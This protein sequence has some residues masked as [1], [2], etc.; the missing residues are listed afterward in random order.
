MI[1]VCLVPMYINISSTLICYLS[2]FI[3]TLNS[4]QNVE[5]LM[6]R[7]EYFTTPP[8]IAVRSENKRHFSEVLRS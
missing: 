8:V 4:H 3:N 5:V 7:K 1:L 6:S 2:I